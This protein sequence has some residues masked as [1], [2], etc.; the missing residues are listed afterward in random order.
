MNFDGSEKER[1]YD[2]NVASGY[3]LN[4]VDDYIYFF[5]TES[6][7]ENEKIYKMKLD[8]SDLQAIYDRR[9]DYMIVDNGWIYFADYDNKNLYK[10]KT[11]GTEQQLLA[12]HMLWV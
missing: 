11:D 9:T 7:T 6:Y 4:I 8:G 10:M 3:T 5:D 12:K 1:I 2:K